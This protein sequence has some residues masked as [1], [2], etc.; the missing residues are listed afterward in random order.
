MNEK[1]RTKNEGKSSKKTIVILAIVILIAAAIIAVAIV[2]SGMSRKNNQTDYIGEQRA[3]E[4]ALADA[5]ISADETAY[6]TAHMDYE[7][8]IAVYEVNFVSG[9]PAYEYDYELR[10][11]DGYILKRDIDLEHDN[12]LVPQ[13][14]N[15]DAGASSGSPGAGNSGV[16]DNADYIGEDK[17]KE[18]ALTDAGIDESQATFTK[19]KLDYDNGTAEYEIEFLSGG[20]EYEYEIDAVSGEI[21]AYDKDTAH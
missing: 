20:M 13:Q 1:E 5:G 18:I 17:A 19:L 6:I 16:S 11:T 8:G 15:S 9:D 14:G 21:I 4:I 2:Y 12:P 7:N 3:Q 10:A